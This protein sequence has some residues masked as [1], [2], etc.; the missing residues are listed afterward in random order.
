[1]ELESISNRRDSSGKVIEATLNQ[2]GTVA[3]LK[4]K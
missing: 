1:M 4:K 2:L 3:V